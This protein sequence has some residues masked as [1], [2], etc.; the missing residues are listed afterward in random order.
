[1]ST[2]EDFRNN[3]GE[4]APDAGETQEQE[5]DIQD[6]PQVD[7]SFEEEGGESQ[8]SSTSVEPQ[9]EEEDIQLSPKEQTAFE[10]RMERER[11]K[12]Q[13]QMEKDFESR[14]S[15]HKAVID[16]LGGDPDKIE[17][18][19]Q[20]KQIELEAQRLAD[21]YGWDDSQVQYYV[22]QESGK[23]QQQKF[24]KELQDLRIANE[25]NELRDNAEF[26]GIMSM[27]KEI[28]DLVSRSGGTLNVTQAYWALGGAQRAKQ[29]QR[30]A[31]QRAALQRRTGRVVAS[32]APTAASSEQAIP[33]SVLADAKRWGLSEKEVRELMNFN[34]TNI[35]EYRQ[36]KA[37]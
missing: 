16:K 33:N 6:E 12:L 25:I 8:P 29:V 35:Q 17:Q 3:T 37:K 23:L 34:A 5:V 31:E 36:K 7:E 9:D 26:S 15:K 20:Q 1:M 28:T 2:L 32:D 10:K 19:L 13:E 18:Q 11:R 22:Q 24:E 21:A 4:F 14:Y 27:K 30:E